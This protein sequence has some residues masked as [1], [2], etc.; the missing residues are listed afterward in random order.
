MHPGIIIAEHVLEPGRAPIADNA[1]RDTNCESACGSNK[2]GSRGYKV[3]AWRMVVNFA[4]LP[5]LLGKAPK[6]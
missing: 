6:S 2:P 4:K 1:R 5:E 3:E